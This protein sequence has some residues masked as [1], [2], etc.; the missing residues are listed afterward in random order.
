MEMSQVLA[1]LQQHSQWPAVNEIY[2]KLTAAGYKAFL[3]GGCVRDALLGRVAHDIDVATDATPDQIEALFEKTVAVGKA[4]GVIRVLTLGADIEVATFRTDGTY[5]DGRRPDHVTFSSPVEDAER[6][7]FTIN[8]LFFDLL[9]KEVIDFVGG[10]EDLNQKIIKAVGDPEKRFREDHLRI[11]RAVRFA[12][13]LGF[14]IESQTFVCLSQ[15]ASLVKSVSGE[16]LREEWTKLLLSPFVEKGLSLAVSSGL[17]QELFPFRA[18]DPSWTA[19]PLHKVIKEPW[20]AMALFL[21][22]ASEGD[23]KNSLQLLKMSTKERK[24][25]EDFWQVRQSPAD[26]FAFRRGE[27]LQ[28]LAKPGVFFA[29]QGLKHSPEFKDLVEGLFENWT[30]LGAVLPKPLVMGADLQ[31]K[32][33][34]AQMGAALQEIFNLQLEEKF[35]DRAQSLKWLGDALKK[36]QWNG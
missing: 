2:H 24:N 15:M 5:Q 4:F 26:F 1:L 11:L 22:S 12:A 14:T 17:M 19:D 3:A 29:L 35:S 34:G 9:Q 23:L 36:G 16:R 25:I 27:Q 32:L 33:Q 6:R 10:K 21:S 20:Q 28:R 8:A 30:K 18:K 31:G 7:D 13:Q